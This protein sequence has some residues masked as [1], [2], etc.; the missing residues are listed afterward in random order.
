MAQT[1]AYAPTTARR[2]WK[3]DRRDRWTDTVRN[4]PHLG[5]GHRETL[6]ACVPYMG[7]DGRFQVQRELLM[8]ETDY[9]HPQRITDAWRAAVDAGLLMLV[10]KRH[11]GMP[12]I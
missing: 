2:R 12:T 1:A 9:T 5:R 3:L 10:T 7:A 11:Q 8:A 4:H 6:L